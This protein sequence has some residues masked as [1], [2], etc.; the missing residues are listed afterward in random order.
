[1]I[2][3]SDITTHEYN[4]VYHAIEKRDIAGSPPTERLT[5]GSPGPPNV[6]CER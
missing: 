5:S 1:M 3:T 2:D 4:I 6:W